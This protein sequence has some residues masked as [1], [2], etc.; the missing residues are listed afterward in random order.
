MN[1]PWLDADVVNDLLIVDVMVGYGYNKNEICTNEWDM[2]WKEVS[3]CRAGQNARDSL[4]RSARCQL[5]LAWLITLMSE[6]ELVF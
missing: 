3:S 2:S 5:G 4:A 6:L 1:W